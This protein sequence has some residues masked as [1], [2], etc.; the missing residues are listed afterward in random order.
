MDI[1]SYIKQLET[2]AN[3]KAYQKTTMERVGERFIEHAIPRTPVDTGLSKNSWQAEA[4]QEKV[5]ITNNAERNGVQYAS[6]WN[7]GTHNADG[8][9]RQ[10]GTHTLQNAA[11]LTLDEF[12]Q[13]A[14]EEIILAWENKK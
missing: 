7:Y 12:P 9:V 5:T 1:T 10:Q 13:I 3:A 11:N 8:S 14:Q 6:Y 2:F 4:S